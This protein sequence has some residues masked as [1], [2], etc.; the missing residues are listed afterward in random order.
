MFML[1]YKWSE[2]DVN[3]VLFFLTMKELYKVLDVR[4]S[5]V[6]YWEIFQISTLAGESG[7]VNYWLLD[8]KE[9]AD[10]RAKVMGNSQEAQK[11][12]RI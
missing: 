7:E 2:E 3:N 11:N 8:S 10:L 12:G 4:L 5:G 6:F 1:Q 9:L